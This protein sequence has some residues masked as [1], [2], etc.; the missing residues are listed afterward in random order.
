M[1]RKTIIS[2]KRKEKFG[3]SKRDSEDVKKLPNEKFGCFSE[4]FLRK[5]NYTS[6][7]ER[8][9]ETGLGKQNIH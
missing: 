4:V 2:K 9:M 6:Y 7:K 5:L 3:T 8:G 1:D